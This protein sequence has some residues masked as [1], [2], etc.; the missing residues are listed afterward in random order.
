[1]TLNIGLVGTGWFSKMHAEILS[2]I[3]D[4]NISGICGSSQVK[5]DKMAQQFSSAKGYES[6]HTL[7][8]DQKL[9]ALYICVPPFAHG[10]IELA[11]V[12][13]NIPF[14]VE[15]P[16]STDLQTPSLILDAIK[17]KNLITSVGYHFRYHDSAQRAKLLLQEQTIGMSLGYWMGN[18][19]GVY[20][21]R[22]QDGSGGQF[23]EQTT[24]IVDLLRYLV[25]DVKEVYAA[26]SN[27][28]LH[29]KETGVDVADVGTVTMKMENGSVATISNTC[30]LPAGGKNGLHIYTD[31][32]VLEVD[33]GN[34]IET[35][36]GRKTEYKNQSNPYETE[37][38]AFLHALRT[39]D[40]SGILSTYADAWKS[41]QVAVAANESAK[42]GK[43][44]IL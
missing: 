32:G 25:G 18:M 36:V 30:I 20:W 3:E 11:A 23:V 26:F 7:L 34:L 33:Q 17:N 31:Q 5:A 15:K 9:D 16:L 39:G 1:M 21:W 13:H 37:T 24:H 10:E 6:I 8:E 44:V 4:V 35:A 29:E 12:E 41:Q 14:F 43:P 42:S 19:P 2:K 27:R 22:K 38:N 40:T 28:V